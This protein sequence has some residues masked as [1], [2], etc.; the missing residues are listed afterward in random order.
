MEQS[1]LEVLLFTNTHFLSQ[2]VSE[3]NDPDRK[4]SADHN[5]LEE[6]CWN[7]FFNDALPELYEGVGENKKLTLWKVLTGQHF[8]ELEYGEYPQVSDPLLSINPYRFLE[9]VSLS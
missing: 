9:A 2:T 7:G 4:R 1:R 8:L 5:D 3:N 6:A